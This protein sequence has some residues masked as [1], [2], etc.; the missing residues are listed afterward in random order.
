MPVKLSQKVQ[1]YNKAYR[2]K[3]QPV[4]YKKVTLEKVKNGLCARCPRAA[5]ELSYSWRGKVIFSKKLWHCPRHLFK[6]KSVLNES[7][8]DFMGI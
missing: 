5:V 1:T 6:L 7:D 4:Y 2:K 3:Y 8:Y